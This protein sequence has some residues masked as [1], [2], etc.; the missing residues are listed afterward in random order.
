[1]ASTRWFGKEEWFVQRGTLG[2]KVPP[3]N[4]SL[5]LDETGRDDH[6]SR[7]PDK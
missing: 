7:Q 1:M 3:L 6:Q 4:L 2:H 5:S